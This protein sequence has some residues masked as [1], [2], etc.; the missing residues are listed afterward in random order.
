MSTLIL[1]DTRATSLPADAR[2]QV[3]ESVVSKQSLRFSMHLINEKRL[4]LTAE[5]NTTVVL[6]L[7]RPLRR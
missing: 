1:N 4:V 7:L 2:L 5:R 6:L 3:Y